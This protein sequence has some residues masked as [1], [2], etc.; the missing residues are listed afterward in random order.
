[1]MSVVR[2]SWR[3]GRA[4]LAMAISVLASSVMAAQAFD[5]EYDAKPW[6]EIAVQLP[7][8]PAEGNLLP[9]S[10]GS[11]RDRQ[12]LVDTN[13]LSIGSDGVVRYSLVIVSSAGARN[14]SYEGLRCETAERRFYA[15]GRPDATWSKARGNQWAAIQGGSNNHHV[16]LLTNYFC[17]IRLPVGSVE[18]I[19]R[20]LRSGGAPAIGK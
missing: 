19:K 14:V 6:A 1:M 18:D 16:E 9:F 2:R 15:F 8:Y 20:R 5:D 12:F 10:V 11:V 17:S 4:G 7:A 3:C 13:S